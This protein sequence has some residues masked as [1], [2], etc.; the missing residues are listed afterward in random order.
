MPSDLSMH[1]V[2]TITP[3][4]LPRRYLNNCICREHLT[5]DWAPQMHGDVAA[6]TAAGW[7]AVKIDSCGPSHH[8]QEW[9]D[10]LNATGKAIQIENCH[11]NTTFPY[12]DGAGDLQCPMHFFRV[13]SDIN[14]A[15]DKIVGNLQCSITFNKL[16]D[17]IARPGCWAY[18]DM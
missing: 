16:R 11:D 3:V 2:L 18:P 17:P 14:G 8:L 5:P 6:L 1:F 15:W 7:D 12:I 9:S 4:F 10:L 13:S